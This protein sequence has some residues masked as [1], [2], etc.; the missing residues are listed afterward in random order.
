[1]FPVLEHG[2]LVGIVTLQ[3]LIEIAARPEERA[4]AVDVM[5]PPFVLGPDED[6]RTAFEM[7]LAHGVRELP[8]TDATGRIIGFVDETS[9]AH[10]YASLRARKTR[11]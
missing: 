10:A 4:T 6:L 9:I 7:M 8:T 2:A 3:D 1:V 11:R 5:R